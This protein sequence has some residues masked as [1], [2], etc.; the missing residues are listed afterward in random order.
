MTLKILSP[1]L[2][3]V[4]LATSAPVFAQGQSDHGG[5]QGDDRRQ[6][7][8]ED[9]RHAAPEHDQHGRH[10]D[11]HGDPR[12]DA[13]PLGAASGF[14]VLSAARG[15]TGAV[16]CTNSSIAGDVGSSGL[17]VSVTQTACA[18][19]GAV[20]APVSTQVLADFNAAYDRFAAIPCTATL[21]AAYTGIALTLAPGVYCSAAAVTFTDTALTLDGQGDANASWLFKIG[22]AGTGALTGTNLSVVLANAGAPCNVNWWVAQAVTMTTSALQGSILAGAAITMTGLAGNTTP[23]N[24]NA[25]AKGPVTLTGI[26]VAGCRAS[27]GP[28]TVPG[29]CNQGVGNGPEHCDPG[30]SDHGRVS[31]FGPNSND[32]LG[33]V[34]GYPG[35]KGGN[36]K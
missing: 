19:A 27:V 1:A 17:P 32:E 23:F 2:V 34:P 31:P 21:D 29:M 15:G 3:A 11:G 35:R 33:G 8:H 18:I 4:L 10:H 13:P 7:R 25:L 28:G 16:T 30:N 6:Q 5:R 24:G 26:T 14:S 22:T 9:G 36:K 20:V 12:R